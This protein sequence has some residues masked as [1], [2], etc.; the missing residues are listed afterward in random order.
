MTIYFCNDVLCHES[1]SFNPTVGFTAAERAYNAG[2]T[3]LKSWPDL[4]GFHLSQKEY[5]F[6]P[7]CSVKLHRKKLSKLEEKLE[8][9]A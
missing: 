3:T 5:I 9:I 1:E 7:V 8:D 4:A 2:W 6:C